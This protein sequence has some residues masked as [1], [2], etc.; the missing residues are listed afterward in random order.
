MAL[1]PTLRRARWMIGMGVM[2]VGAVL[3]ANA[4]FTLIDGLAGLAEVADAE[5][6]HEASGRLLDA[7]PRGVNGAMWGLGFIAVGEL[8]ILLPIGSRGRRGDDIDVPSGYETV[9]RPKRGEPVENEAA[10]V[11]DPLM[12]K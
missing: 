2:L 4:F 5:K 12:D 11:F 9:T 8:I 1:Q 10:D 3:V 6:S 7:L